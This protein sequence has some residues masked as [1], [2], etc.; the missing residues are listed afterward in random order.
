[1]RNLTPFVTSI[2]E[3]AT[4]KEASDKLNEH[5][6]LFGIVQWHTIFVDDRAYIHGLIF[7]DQGGINQRFIN[8]FGVNLLEQLRVAYSK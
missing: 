8:I 6:G 4:I 3:G 7:A 5:G 1:M 2:I